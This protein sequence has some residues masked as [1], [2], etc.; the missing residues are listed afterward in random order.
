MGII[1]TLL[2]YIKQF[3]ENLPLTPPV[4]MNIFYIFSMILIFNLLGS[5]LYSRIKKMEQRLISNEKNLFQIK[6]LYKEIVNNVKS[7]ILIVN[8][9]GNIL[10]SNPS[11]MRILGF[12]P[13]GKNFE[14]IFHQKID[15]EANREELVTEINGR[16][17]IAGMSSSRILLQDED[18]YLIVFQDLTRIKEMEEKLLEAEK[19]A[20][21]GEMASNI[22][23]ELRNP[24]ATIRASSE[25]LVEE[26]GNQYAGNKKASKIANILISE[27]ERIENLV[28]QI[29]T[30]SKEITLKMEKVNLPELLER[31][32]LKF[33]Q[34]FPDVSLTIEGKKDAIIDGDPMWLE[35]AF[36]NLIQNS[37]DAIGDKGKIFVSITKNGTNYTLFFSDSGDGIPREIED[38]IFQ[39]FFTT[40]RNGTGL[41]L[42]LTRK[43]ITAHGGIIQ[44]DS[45]KKG[46][47]II[48]PGEPR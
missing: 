1:F 26:I 32:F 19:F 36:S 22:A 42:A 16:K 47:T 18:L 40:K 24:L 46:F 15:Q 5:F 20:V 25:L 12:D 29:L 4:M 10:Y 27:S 28:K 33:Q 31:I 48:F 39:P 43:I 9:E 6:E 11:G 38:K 17:L 35:E 8:Q 34:R 3:Q 45:E 44:W 2:T 41:G 14:N 21:I 23:H 7:G 13:V 37:I 30:Y